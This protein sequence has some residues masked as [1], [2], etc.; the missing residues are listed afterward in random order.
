MQ[1][2]APGYNLGI[3]LQCFNGEI[4]PHVYL[5]PFFLNKIRVLILVLFF[6]KYIKASAKLLFNRLGL[7]LS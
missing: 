1:N 2:D 6:L 4:L 3:P 5:N 7:A